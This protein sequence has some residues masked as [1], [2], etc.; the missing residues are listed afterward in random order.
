MILFIGDG[1]GIS[2][3]TAARILEGQRRGES[4]E[5]N[6]L[7]FEDFSYS[8]LVRTYSANQQ[9]SDSAPTA[10]AMV[11]GWHVNE[12]TLGVSPELPHGTT[13]A[14]TVMRFSLPTLLEQAGQRG[15]QA[16]RQPGLQFAQGIFVG[17]GCPCEVVGS[18][19]SVQPRDL[20]LAIRSSVSTGLTT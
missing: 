4:G 2:T 13:D 18:D 14:A 10:T 15:L 6:H 7:S 20:I 9:T 3:I 8:A 5:Q 12:D 16:A 19:R 17:H 1:M 11:T